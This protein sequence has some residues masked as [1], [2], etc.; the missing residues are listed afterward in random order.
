MVL[1]IIF[2]YA[3]E[4]KKGRERPGPNPNGENENQS[5]N[6]RVAAHGANGK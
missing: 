6:P 1:R 4:K 3:P 5:V 2:I